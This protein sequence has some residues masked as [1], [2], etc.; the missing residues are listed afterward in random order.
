[1]DVDE[2]ASPGTVTFEEVLLLRLAFEL[3]RSTKDKRSQ[4]YLEKLE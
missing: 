1:M 4:E 3:N 2:S